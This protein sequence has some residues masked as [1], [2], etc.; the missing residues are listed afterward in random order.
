[1]KKYIILLLAAVTLLCF[2]T[3]CDIRGYDDGYQNGYNDG[4]EIGWE[5][6]FDEGYNEELLW[7]GSESYDEGYDSGYEDGY[8]EGDASG[9]YAGATYTCL[10]YGDV[11]RAFQCAINGI[12]WHTFLDAYHEFISPIYDIDQTRSALFWA[13]FSATS[14]SGVTD[15]EKNLLISTFGED[16]FV[17]NGV[18]LE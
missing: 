10:Y 11:D 3:S 1:M 5:K 12:V 16:L 7:S 6:G 15:E 8:A 14:G 4:Y 9:Y 13:L 2:L 17:R 18:T